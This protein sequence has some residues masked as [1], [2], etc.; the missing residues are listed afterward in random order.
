MF[1]ASDWDLWLNK[2]YYVSVI[3]FNTWIINN[4]LWIKLQK[5]TYDYEYSELLLYQN[6]VMREAGLMED[7]LEHINTYKDSICDKVT[8]LEI[9]GECY[10]VLH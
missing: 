3:G 2:H 1:I 8:S 5:N 10:S 7:A 6:M 9:R 4:L